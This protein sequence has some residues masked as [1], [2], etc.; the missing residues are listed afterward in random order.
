M[1]ISISP[2]EYKAPTRRDRSR[3]A[4]KKRAPEGARLRDASPVYLPNDPAGQKT[5]AHQQGTCTQREQ[6]GTTRGGKRAARSS[7]SGAA[8]SSTTTAAASRSGATTAGR[9]GRRNAHRSRSRAATDVN[10]AA[11]SDALEAGE[12]LVLADA[13]IL[14][15]ASEILLVP[16]V[17]LAGGRCLDLVAVHVLDAATDGG[18]LGESRGCGGQDHGHNRGQQHYL[19][20]LYLL[21]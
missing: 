10:V 19:P 20:H 4:R 7:R 3:R 14:R 1:R 6:R 2:P 5:T 21:H 8:S 16:D 11:R 18:G 12:H 9:S 13:Q 15:D 17:V